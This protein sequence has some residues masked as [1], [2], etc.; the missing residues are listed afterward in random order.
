M[1]GSLCLLST[2]IKILKRSLLSKK[3]D[4]CV[5]FVKQISGEVFGVEQGQIQSR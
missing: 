3:K 5:L 4:M 2:I 1:I